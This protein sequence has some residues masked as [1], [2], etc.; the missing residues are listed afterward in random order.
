MHPALFV[1]L[2]HPP[3]CKRVESRIE[4]GIEQE[5]GQRLMGDGGGTLQR[6]LRLWRH[7]QIDAFRPS[8]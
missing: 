5:L 1:E 7:A 3:V 4:P 6:T 8:F 2:K